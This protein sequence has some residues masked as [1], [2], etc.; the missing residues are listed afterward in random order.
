M[1]N[2][3]RI[4]LSASII[5]IHVYS[6]NDIFHTTFTSIY[7]YLKIN[8][9][10][11]EYHDTNLLASHGASVSLYNVPVTYLEDWFSSFASFMIG[12]LY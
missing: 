3:H 11:F 7:F 2:A 6:I 8:A 12:Y 4:S 1:N 9:A 5:L 10:A